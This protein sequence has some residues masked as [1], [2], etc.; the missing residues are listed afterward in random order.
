[1]NIDLEKVS[2]T[3]KMGRETVRALD[4]VTFSIKEGSLISVVGPSGS[5]KTTLMNIIGTLDRPTSGRVMADGRDLTSLSDRELSSLRLH[6]IGIIFQQFHLIQSLTALENIMLP[7]REGGISRSGARG[8]SAKLLEMQ[9]IRRRGDHLPSQLSGGEQQLVAIARSLAN[10]PSLVLAD[11][12]TGELDSANS[13]RITEV[14]RRL[15]RE[16]GKTVV[17]VTH[18]LSV[19]KR[20]DRMVKIRDGRIHS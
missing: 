20:T 4:N 11:E 8:R 14:L 7:M 9:G 12:P 17:V 5:G 15:N 2:K 3:Y 19:A 6:G 16:L 1:M 13:K 18:D 10:D